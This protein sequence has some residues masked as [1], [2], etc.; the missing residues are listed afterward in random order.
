M[1]RY[2]IDAAVGGFEEVRIVLRGQEYQLGTTAAQL[3]RVSDIRAGLAAELKDDKVAF[4]AALVGPA[5]RTLAPD[6]GPVLDATP[7]TAAE[8][9]ALMRPLA[10]VLGQL[11]RFRSPTG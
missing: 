2:D 1:K 9:M 4:A 6:V 10:E 7:L 3:L 5:L 11:S 8:E